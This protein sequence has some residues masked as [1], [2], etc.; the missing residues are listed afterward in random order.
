[1]N[2]HPVMNNDSVA[3]F[4]NA[5]ARY[6]LVNEATIRLYGC[7]MLTSVVP[8]EKRTGD[9]TFIFERGRRKERRKKIIGRDCSLMTGNAKKRKLKKIPLTMI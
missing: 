1:M 3:S 4:T 2:G 9:G 8:P 7:A 5:Y 6:T